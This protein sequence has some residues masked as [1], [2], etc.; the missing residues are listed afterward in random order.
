MKKIR[1]STRSDEFARAWRKIAKDNAEDLLRSPEVQGTL[2][3][4]KKHFKQENAWGL[5]FQ[6]YASTANI[7]EY[8]GFIYLLLKQGLTVRLNEKTCVLLIEKV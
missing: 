8:S 3:D 6:F 5:N 4:I 7:K 1:K 2:K